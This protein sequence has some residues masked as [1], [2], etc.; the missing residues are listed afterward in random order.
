M[1]SGSAITQYMAVRE[2]NLD[3]EGVSRRREEV[4]FQITHIRF[5]GK[6]VEVL[7]TGMTAGLTVTVGIATGLRFGW[8]LFGENE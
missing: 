2:G 3:E 8:H 1:R 5:Y 6:A 4:S 7:D